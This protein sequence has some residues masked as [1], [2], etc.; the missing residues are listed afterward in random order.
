MRSRR[1][2]TINSRRLTWKR[3]R[4]PYTRLQALERVRKALA[5]MSWIMTM[6]NQD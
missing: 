1:G 4:P 3:T 6:R 5:V 2:A